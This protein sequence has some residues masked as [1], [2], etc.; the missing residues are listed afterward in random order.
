MKHIRFLCSKSNHFHPL[1]GSMFCR[2][3]P[4]HSHYQMRKPAAIQ[5]SSFFIE[6]SKSQRVFKALRLHSLTP[7]SKRITHIRLYCR[8]SK[9]KILGIQLCWRIQYQNNRYQKLLS[10]FA[11]GTSCL[12]N[13]QSLQCIL[14]SLRT[15]H[16]LNPKRHEVLDRS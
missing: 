12:L 6:E 15:Y 3:D 10:T 1:H 9:L 11:S 7:L 2:N 5:A 4:P 13:N 8:Y 16:G 14:H